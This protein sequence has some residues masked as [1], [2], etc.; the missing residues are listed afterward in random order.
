MNF[1]KIAGKDIKSIFKNR[2]IRVSVIAIII[3]P[4]LYSLLYLDAFWDPYARIQDMTIAVV[5]EDGGALLDGKE[6]N[7]GEDIVENLKGNEE[8]G[9]DFTS[10]EK[11]NEGLEKQGYYAKFVIPKDFSKSVVAAKEGKPQVADLQFVCNEKKNFLAA[12]INSQVEKLLKEEI[13]GTISNNYVT[14]AFDKLYEAKDG[15]IKATDGS[16]KL[17][18]GIGELNEKVPMLAEGANQLGDG[19]AQLK[20]G[21]GALNSGIKSINNGLSEVNGKVPTLGSGV[22]KLYNGSQELKNGLSEANSKVSNL[23][24][25]VNKLYDGSGA[26]TGGSK[27][28]YSAFNTRI[29][30]NV[31]LLKDGANKLNGKLK[32]GESSV[33][34]LKEG[35][36]KLKTASDDVAA[37]S[38]AINKGYQESVKG[39]V[40]KLISGVNKS[41]EKMKDISEDIIT[42]VN[43]NPEVAK[44][45]NIQATLVNIQALNEAT[46]ETPKQIQELQAGTKKFGDN[47]GEFNGSVNEYTGKVNGFATGTVALTDSVSDIGVAVNKISGGLN[48]LEAGLNE[49]T[50]DSFGYG[51]KSVSDNMD[52]LN[53]GLGELKNNIPALSGGIQALYNGSSEIYGGL[54]QLR[55]NIPTLSG[56]IQALYNGSNQLVDGSNALVDG[57]N[58]LNDGVS[59][60][61]GKV[62]QLED[63][64]DKLYKGSNELATALKD[65]AG[66]MKSGLKNSS[67]EMGDFV[68]APINMKNEPINKVP[69]YG[70]GFAPY[71]I[72]LSLWIGAI[73]MFFVISA[74]TDDDANLSK[75]DKVIGKYLS[76]GFIGLLQALLVS[77]VVMGLG[78]T[79]TSTVMYFVSIVFLSLVFIAIIQCLISLF[80]DAGRLLGIVLLILQLTACAGTFP[81]EI[82][83]KFFKVINPYMPFTYSVELLR[84]VISA[85]TINYGIVGKDFLILG[86]VLLVF[87]TIS[88]VFKNAGEN[89]QNIIEG[90]KGKS[91]KN[92]KEQSM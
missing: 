61:T 34:K 75:F 72:S 38:T 92:I 48:S 30:P 51:L 3:V 65:G 57:Q 14:V 8:V 2:F 63:G 11:A 52:A 22:E 9:W 89:L 49:N 78:L 83:P 36:E 35:G 70:T 47:L 53:S 82:V 24:P 88:I 46:S 74:K 69:N 10:N 5:N 86:I 17:Y 21:Q 68:S 27:S 87:L 84:E 85:N 40:D 25:G 23:S 41:S 15:F 62:P 58:K 39:G 73:M 4:L 20:N 79:P 77:A 16:E 50:K 71:F 32:D 13:V 59:E 6:V 80:G 37:S 60:L 81:L 26:L 54:G 12:Q 28:L 42:A 29:Y 91:V 55:S 33:K 45:P 1:L 67:E 18:N 64:V 76:F 56:G 90:R 44:D 7:Y 19:S 43:S 66:E 31:N